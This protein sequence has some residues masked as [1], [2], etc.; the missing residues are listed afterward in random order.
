MS[1]E[2]IGD[3]DRNRLRVHGALLMLWSALVGSAS[4][5]LLLHVFQVHSVAVRYCVGAAAVYFL[6]FLVGARIYAASWLQ[7]DKR[8]LPAHASLE[9]AEEISANMAFANWSTL[10]SLFFEGG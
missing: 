5:A 7:D 1:L 2:F 9:R 6:G 3:S 8:P 10:I 4:S